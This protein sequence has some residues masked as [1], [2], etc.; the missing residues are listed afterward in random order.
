MFSSIGTYVG[1]RGANVFPVL[2]RKY[3]PKPLRVFLQDGSHDLNIY[4]G[5]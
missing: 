2:I 3:E 1:L 5:D 4:C